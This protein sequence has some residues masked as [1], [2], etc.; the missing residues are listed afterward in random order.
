MESKDQIRECL[1]QLGGLKTSALSKEFADKRFYANDLKMA[2]VAYNKAI[3]LESPNNLE[4]LAFLY[5]SVSLCH[6]KLQEFESGVIFARKSIDANPDWFGGFFRNAQN[7]MGLEK[8]DEA[9]FYA[10]LAYK[11]SPDNDEIIE[12]IKEIKALDFAL[13]YDKLEENTPTSYYKNKQISHLMEKL[14]GSVI[15]KRKQLQPILSKFHTE[16]KEAYPKDKSGFNLLQEYYNDL[17]TLERRNKMIATD[18]G[19]QMKNIGYYQK[20]F[21][22]AF[23]LL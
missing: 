9:D 1:I 5:S 19:E 3:Q 17:C 22:G 21:G 20:R 15:L 8:Y 10:G 18:A 13:D 14:S 2:K 16:Y 4:K 23:T 6:Y 7:L 11:M 12:I